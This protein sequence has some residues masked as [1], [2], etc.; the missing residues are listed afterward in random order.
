MVWRLPWT[1]LKREPISELNLP[2]WW[3]GKH[4]S[5]M[6]G[7][8]VCPQVPQCASALWTGRLWLF[9][10]QACQRSL[11]SAKGSRTGEDNID[12]HIACSHRITSGRLIPQVSVIAVSLVA[13]EMWGHL[14]LRCCCSY[15]SSRRCAKGK[16]IK[17]PHSLN[18]TE[19]QWKPLF[20]KS[21]W[22]D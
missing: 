6:Q 7:V 4:L 15:R 9:L 5:D 19:S 1:G 8:R 16:N 3:Y 22:H 14:C 2:T 13:G 12:I 18:L 20:K 21:F 10:P 11:C 17:P